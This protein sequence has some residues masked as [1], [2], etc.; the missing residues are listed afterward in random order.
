MHSPQ[1]DG[2]E[3]QLA[4]GMFIGLIGLRILKCSATADCTIDLRCWSSSA[5]VSTVFV[6]SHAEV[7][8]FCISAAT[9]CDTS[10]EICLD[11]LGLLGAWGFFATAGL[12]A[13][14]LFCCH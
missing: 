13:S 10:I 4:G 11:L 9:C 12:C 2:G 8:Y 7:V 5:V 6:L 14:G 3:D 1:L